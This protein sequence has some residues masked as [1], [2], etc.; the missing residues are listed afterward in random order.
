MSRTS[1]R[2]RYESFD[3][4]ERTTSRPKRDP[5]LYVYFKGDSKS[6]GDIARSNPSIFLGNLKYINAG[7]EIKSDQIKCD[8]HIVRITCTNTDEQKRLLYVANIAGT[9]GRPY[10]ETKRKEPDEN[11]MDVRVSHV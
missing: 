4:N 6:I 5:K 3:T 7:I 11:E 10:A 1:K 8:K 2:S 9:A